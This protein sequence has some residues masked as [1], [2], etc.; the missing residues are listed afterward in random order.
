MT[1]FEVTIETAEAKTLRLLVEA[2]HWVDAWQEGSAIMGDPPSPNDASCVIDGALARVDVPST[3]RVYVVR[4]LTHGPPLRAR[5]EP[6]K[7]LLLTTDD[8]RGPSMR[9]QAAAHAPGALPGADQRPRASTVRRA[10]PAD[11]TV[12]DAP[13]VGADDPVAR[14]LSDLERQRIMARPVRIDAHGM[15]QPIDGRRRATPQSMPRVSLPPAD[16]RRLRTREDTLAF[17]PAMASP[18]DALPQQFRPVAPTGATDPALPSAR[19]SALQWAVDTAWLHVPCAVALLLDGLDSELP[20]VALARGERER[21]TRGC[22]VP[23]EHSFRQAACRAPTRVRFADHARI[24]FLSPDDQSFDVEVESTLCAPIAF[25][26]G[27]ESPSTFGLGLV[28]LNSTRP[29]GFTDSELSA[30]TYLA[31]TL[32]ERLDALQ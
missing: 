11:L 3:G 26:P 32:A 15:P 7:P 27:H 25:V 30:L 29:T 19:F 10:R 21:E 5:P 1:T 16:D 28:L 22:R 17:T 8:P 14:V 12:P 24:R 4:P 23:L 6:G 31:R 13:A 2:E 18:S 9:V 20:E